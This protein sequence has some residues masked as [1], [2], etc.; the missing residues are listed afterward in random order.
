MLYPNLSMTSGMICLHQ[1]RKKNSLKHTNSPV[2]ELEPFI[3]D[4][5]VES[6]SLIHLRLSINHTLYYSLRRH[7]VSSWRKIQ[8]STGRNNKLCQG[9]LL[10]K[11]RWIIFHLHPKL[12]EEDPSNLEKDKIRICS[13]RSSYIEDCEEYSYCGS[14]DSSTEDNDC[15]PPLSIVRGVDYGSSCYLQNLAPLNVM[16]RDILPVVHQYRTMIKINFSSRGYSHASKVHV[17]SFVHNAPHIMSKLFDKECNN[18]LIKKAE[19][20]DEIAFIHNDETMDDDVARVRH[21]E[22]QDHDNGIQLHH[23][24]VTSRDHVGT[25]VTE[26][27]HNTLSAAK[28][29]FDVALKNK[30]NEEIYIDDINETK[31]K[32]PSCDIL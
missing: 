14:N 24:F 16:E 21:N 28:S 18:T 15:L 25:G 6:A 17:I 13:M 5:I 2:T 19:K 8:N 29:V 9:F 7:L 4:P 11:K 20:V 31:M 3:P 30:T 1:M 27:E 23:R 22:T 12:V 26:A 10:M 32:A